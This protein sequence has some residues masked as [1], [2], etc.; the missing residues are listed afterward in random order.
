MKKLLTIAASC[1]VLSVMLLSTSADAQW[2]GPQRDGIYPEV[3]LLDAWPESGPQLLWSTDVIGQGFSTIAA[4]AD[5]VYATGL[6]EETGYLFAFD[7]KGKLVWKS[8]YG[9]E[10]TGSYP[11]ARST[12]TVAGDRVYLMSANGVVACFDTAGKKVWSVD[13]A[14]Q[15]KAKQVKWGLT[16][17]LLVDGDRIFCT[18]GG[19]DV[20]LVCLG[21]HTGKVVW[22]NKGNGE[23][24][25]YCSPRL[26]VLG[27]KQVVLTM[28][29]KSVVCVNA[30]SGE[31]L[32]RHPHITSYDVNPNTPLYHDGHLLAFSGYGTGAQKLKLAP[33]ARGVEKLWDQKALDSQFG[34]AI[35]IDG[36]LYGSGQKS[37]GWHCVDWETGEVRY[38]TKILGNKGNII[39]ADGKA[40]CYGEKGD[41]GLV[42]LGPNAFEVISQFSVEQGSG[43]HWAHLVIHDGRLYARHGEALMVYD[44]SSK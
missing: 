15:F 4:S 36:F 9:P 43:Q 29:A 27:D 40:Y 34:S 14:K 21:R 12:P 30:G 22:A 24:T 8:S 1:I 26:A 38:T 37:S 6:I 3:G 28:T 25:A 31:S 2:R 33:N 44:I 39:Y 11:G 7:H 13:I 20:T 32:W 19:P 10:W 42:K 5:R 16:E 23:Q 41:I 35:L 17:S 18:P